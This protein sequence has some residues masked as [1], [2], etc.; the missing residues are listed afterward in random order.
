MPDRGKSALDLLKDR[1]AR[2]EIDRAEYEDRK[3]FLSGRKPG[4]L[5]PVVG[6]EYAIAVHLLDREARTGQAIT[7]V[8]D[9]GS[10]DRQ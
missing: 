4:R 1:F 5:W 6:T 2:G 7:R 3:K 8:S 10:I 9:E